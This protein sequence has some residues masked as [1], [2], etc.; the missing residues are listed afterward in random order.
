MNEEATK[1]ISEIE[2]LQHIIDTPFFMFPV[3]YPRNNS[4]IIALYGDGGGASIYKICDDYTI[5]DAEGEEMGSDLDWF[6]DAGYLYYFYIP[7]AMNYKLWFE[8]E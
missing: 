8:Q 6:F 1:G 5:V 7:E 3:D 4:K 2:N